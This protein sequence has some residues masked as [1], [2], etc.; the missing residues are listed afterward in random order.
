MDY[1]KESGHWYDKEGNPAYTVIGKNGK[2][3]ST[4]LRDAK[5]LNLVPS[6]TTI[7]KLIDKPGLTEWKINQAILSA[8]TCPRINDESE[9][10]YLSRI[11]KDAQE[12]A[13]KAAERGTL[14]HAYVQEGFEGKIYAA[15]QIN[16]YETA[17]AVV[18]AECGLQEWICEK[19]FA[20]DRFGGKC[21]LHCDDF[22]LDIKS[23]D[24]NIDDL[25]TWLDQHM[26]MAGYNEGLGIPDKY[27]Y[28]KEGWSGR[29]CGILYINS[30]TAKARIVWVTEKEIQKGL[31]M[32]LA[33]VEL[34][35]A[36]SEL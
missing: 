34:W 21:D 4:D 6:V 5:K 15:E 26:Q 1:P 8:L 22:L 36:R 11:K 3:R 12:Q 29:K 18:D 20:T 32:F 7:L 17:G 33:A 30:V 16:F 13:K 10:A 23:T 28:L 27:A 24:K 19:S 9:M 31:R 35:Y 14:I 25:T 2:E